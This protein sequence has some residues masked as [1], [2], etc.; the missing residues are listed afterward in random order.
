MSPAGESLHKRGEEFVSDAVRLLSNLPDSEG[1]PHFTVKG[2]VYDLD[3]L[4]S[5]TTGGKTYKFDILINSNAHKSK[6][7]LVECKEIKSKNPDKSNRRNVI[8]FLRRV[9][10][11]MDKAKEE[12]SD[13]VQ[14]MLVTNLALQSFPPNGIPIPS[15]IRNYF[16]NTK[17]MEISEDDVHELCNRVIELHYPQWLRDYSDE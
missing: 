4:I 15:T 9:H 12:Y 2:T 8:S 3:K 14:F 1:K 10:L 7:I 11:C 17:L 16:R 6:Y 5:I 13:K